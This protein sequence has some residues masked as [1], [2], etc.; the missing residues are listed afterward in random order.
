LL[1]KVFLIPLKTNGLISQEQI[2]IIFSELQVIT[3]YNRMLLAQLEQRVAKWNY[4]ACIGDIFQKIVLLIIV[5]SIDYTTH[6]LL[7]FFKH[8]QFFCMR[9][10]RLIF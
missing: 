6:A 9:D 1:F 7:F 2:R 5:I 3:A 8:L 10:P 4:D